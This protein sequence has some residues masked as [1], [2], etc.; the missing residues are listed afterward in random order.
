MGLFYGVSP[1]FQSPCHVELVLGY[2]LPDV[3]AALLQRIIKALLDFRRFP[4]ILFHALTSLLG[5]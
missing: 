2:S 4:L 3:V 1:G 5:V